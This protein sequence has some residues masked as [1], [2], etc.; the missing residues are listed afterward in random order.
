MSF[1]L[2]E[3]KN[4]RDKYNTRLLVLQEFVPLLTE[5][6]QPNYSQEK[7]SLYPKIEELNELIAIGENKE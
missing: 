1:L 7:N 2:D 6:D 4:R 3:I 5:D